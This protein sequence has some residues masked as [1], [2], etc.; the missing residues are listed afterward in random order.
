MQNSSLPSITSVSDLQGKYVLVRS[1]L[2]VPIKDGQ[3]Q[4]QFRLMRSLMT[5]QFLVKQ[6]ARVIVCGH[7]S[8]NKDAEKSESLKPVYELL[9]QYLD[10]VFSDEVV[11]PHTKE[12]R[13]ALG[14]GQV[15]LLENLRTDPREKKN[16]FDFARALA[17]LAQIYVN[18]AFSASHR[19][20]ASLVGVP[21]FLP[22]YFG[23]NFM[24]EHE[25]LTKALKPESP[26]LFVLGGAKF[27]TK[28]PLVEKFLDVYDHVFIGGAL[29][30]DFFKAKGYE[31]GTSLVSSI[32]LTGSPLLTDEKIIIPSD[33]VVQ[34][35]SGQKRTC[36]TT[37]VHKD[38]AIFDIGPETVK[39]LEL[40]V[41]N[42]KIVLWNGP[43]GNYEAGFDQQ[44]LSFA[45][46]VADAEGY[47][48]VG[49]GDTIAAIATLN[50]QEK[51]SFLS[52][53]GGAMLTFLEHG[54]LPA[55][56]AVL[57]KK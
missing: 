8:N 11:T 26:S 13:D 39:T 45:Q 21:Q 28:M 43:F 18:D 6:G 35:A 36:I 12:K 4:N 29:A 24:H 46:L 2:N 52:T 53:A 30:N 19:E 5:L 22:S 15:L 55:I 48:V 54:S 25:E 41:R 1:A 17:E 37:D 57:A 42:S 23:I 20:H 16:D 32:D 7:I 31:V 33:V 38:E 49:G 9:T 34:N 14:D 27:D 40:F 44:T 3:V 56:D 47:S 10:I 50:C 51:F